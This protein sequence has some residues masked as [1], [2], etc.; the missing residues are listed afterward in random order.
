[1]RRFREDN[2][3]WEYAYGLREMLEEIIEAASERFA[4]A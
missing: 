1:M 3:D 4:S 2:P